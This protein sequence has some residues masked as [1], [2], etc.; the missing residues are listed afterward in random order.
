MWGYVISY[1]DT[2]VYL[3]WWS[4]ICGG[5]QY[6]WLGCCD[7]GYLVLYLWLNDEYIWYKDGVDIWIDVGGIIDVACVYWCKMVGV[8]IKI[9]V[10]VT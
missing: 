3:T 9:V 1:H 5:V 10:W 6:I 7:M 2:W 4:R 8:G